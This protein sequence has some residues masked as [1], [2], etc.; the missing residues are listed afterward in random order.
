MCFGD[1]LLGTGIKENHLGL[2]SDYFKT[3]ESNISPGEGFIQTIFY[4]L[5]EKSLTLTQGK[6]CNMCVVLA[7]TR[8]I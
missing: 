6:A 5:Q 2:I 8:E 3:L 4:F 7:Q 1:V